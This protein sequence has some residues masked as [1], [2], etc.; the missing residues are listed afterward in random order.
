MPIYKICG[1]CNQMI[2]SGTTC[3]CYASYRKRRYKEYDISRGEN[4]YTQFYKTKEWL[5]IRDKA[6]SFYD[7]LDIYSYYKLHLIEYG[8]TMHHIVE[9]KEDWAK[10]LDLDNLIFLTE[11]N[12]RIIHKR[13][14]EENKEMVRKELK[15]L[16]KR[17][18]EEMNL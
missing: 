12:H 15:E 7:G 4:K 8:R 1:R 11:S 5:M 6:I 16:I 17:W 3:K 14:Q 18:K 2:P 10:R 13:M 9:M